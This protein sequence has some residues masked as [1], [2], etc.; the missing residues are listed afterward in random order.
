MGITDRNA[1]VNAV[2]IARDPVAVDDF[3]VRRQQYLEPQIVPLRV[4]RGDENAY[5]LVA[6]SDIH[7]I[8]TN[9]FIGSAGQRRPDRRVG[10]E[11]NVWQDNGDESWSYAPIVLFATE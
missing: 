9:S 11:R 1:S 4:R 10:I 5:G 8:K 2:P 3:R 6:S 7:H